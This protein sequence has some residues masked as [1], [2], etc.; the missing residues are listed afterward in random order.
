MFEDMFTPCLI[1]YL[2][3]LWYMFCLHNIW[4]HIQTILEDMLTQ[5]L[6]RYFFMFKAWLYNVWKHIY[7]MFEDIIQFC[8]RL[9]YIMFHGIFT[10]SLW[11]V[12]KM[13]EPILIQNWSNCSWCWKWIKLKMILVKMLHNLPQFFK[14]FK[15]LQSVFILFC[16]A[17][18]QLQTQ[19]SW[20]LS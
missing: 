5:C 2:C 13:F 11:N 8:F 4:S 7:A 3:I 12:Y 10:P 14:W 6:K 1:T 16:Q 19:L 17:Q 20:G 18:P 15:T 9:I